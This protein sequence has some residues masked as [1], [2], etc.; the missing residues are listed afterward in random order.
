[1]LPTCIITDSNACLDEETRN[2]DSVVVIPNRIRLLG[3]EVDEDTLDAVEMFSRLEGAKGNFSD[4]R[5]L[6]LPPP[7]AAVEAAF[8]EAGKR[9]QEVLAIHVSGHFSPIC[10][11]MEAAT[12]NLNGL[13]AR[14]LDSHT[15]SAGLGHLVARAVASAAAGQTMAQISRQVIGEIPDH[16]VSFF[17]ESM[18]YLQRGAPMAQSQS[19]V[20]AMLNLKTMLLLEDG[21]LQPVEKVGS[22]EELVESLYGFIAEFTFIREIGIMNHAYES[23]AESLKARILEDR[24]RLPI[25]EI[26]YPPSLAAHLGPNVVGVVIHEGDP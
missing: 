25:A 1:M 22:H 6:V 3:E 16:F 17:A 11:T 5:P 24:P 15:V 9:G 19:L 2:S 7:P 26:P 13:A 14:V 18:H 4:T 12:R 20:S 23:V 8:G 21:Q 10:R